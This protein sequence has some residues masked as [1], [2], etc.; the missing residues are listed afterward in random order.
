MTL[1]EKWAALREKRWVRWAID[2]ALLF[3]VVASIGA[4]QTRAH[5]R[6]PAPEFSMTSLSGSTISNAT[7]KGKPTLVV[8]WAPWCA[9]CKTES[10]NVS[11]AMKLAGSSANVVSVA[12]AFTDLEQVK[13][14]V[15]ERDVDY[16]VAIDSG[17]V[18]EAFRVQAF[19]TAYFLDAKGELKHS[20]VGY[21]TTAGLLMRLF[22]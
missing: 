2:A 13:G 18:A 11:W 20:A 8:F 5:L 7:L 10:Q 16:P 9:V 12:T 4:W 6:G 1:K 19:P 3:G 17:G 22:L 21:T 14:Y 15:N